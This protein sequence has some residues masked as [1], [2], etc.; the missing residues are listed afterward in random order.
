MSNKLVG[1][2]GNGRR[3]LFAG[4]TFLVVAGLLGAACS[5]SNTTA[6]S[7][8]SV[9][10]TVKVGYF[11]NITHGV[12]LVGV[13]NGTF[14]RDLAPDKL[15]VSQTFNAGP[16]ETQALLSKAIDIAFIG[17]SPSIAAFAQSNGAVKIISGAASGG[18]GLVTK[19]SITSPA[20]LK[21]KTLATPQ[22]GNTQDVALRAYLK[23]QGLKTDLE[24]GGDVS[25]KPQ[26]NSQTVTTFKASGIDGAWVPEPFLSLLVAAGGHVLVD[27]KALWPAGQFVTTNVLVRTDFLQAH[28]ATVKRFLTGVVDTIQFIGSNSNQAQT[29]AN[30]QL[31]SLGSALAPATL[32][33]AWSNLTFTADPLA[34]SLK[35]EA[36]DAVAV[37]LLTAPKL[38]GIFDLTLLNQVLK[39]KGQT[40]VSS[41]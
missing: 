23:T 25:I 40:E 27:E 2:D 31:T 5:S 36:A 21:G 14:A 13:Q 12:A 8:T 22:L 35:K 32:S 4:L 10:V 41:T 39:G 9:P 17:P 33:A 34:S 28:P 16:A 30:Q 15:D 3:H 26:S 7:T 24:G 37:G 18:A 11:P 1:K 19:A 20:D 29:A 6:A 38:D